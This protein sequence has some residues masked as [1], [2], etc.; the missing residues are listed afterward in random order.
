MQWL[1][2]P[3][4]YSD[5]QDK[6]IWWVIC[7]LVIVCLETALSKSFCLCQCDLCLVYVYSES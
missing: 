5:D 7:G 2:T 3:T 6:N 4:G 1:V